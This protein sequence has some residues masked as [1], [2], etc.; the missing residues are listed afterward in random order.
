M[1]K[2][3]RTERKKH[4]NAGAAVRIVIWL[5]V[6]CLLGGLFAVCLMGYYGGGENDGW[7]PLIRNLGFANSYWYDDS[8]YSVGDHAFTERITALDIDWL[9]GCVTIIPGEGDT[10]TLQEQ[11]SVGVTDTRDQLRWRVADGKLTVKFCGPSRLLAFDIPAKSLTVTVPAAW[12]EDMTSVKLDTASASVE[13]NGLGADR[14]D[15]DTASGTVTLTDV[16]VREL[17]VNTVSGRIQVTNATADTADMDTTSG[18]I[19][20]SGKANVVDV[21][22]VSGQ[23]NL[24]LTE[25]AG[26]VSVSST[27]GDISVTG[28]ADEVDLD[29]TSGTMT[30]TLTQA[31]R[32]VSADSVSGRL[33]IHL[34]ATVPGF[35]VDLDSVSGEITVN[36]FATEG[37]NRHRVY[38]DGSMTIDCDTVSGNVTISNDAESTN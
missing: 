25:K 32:K 24:T 5:L 9:E 2:T 19:T 18:N 38:G 37:G 22:T 4:A 21:D 12:L 27:S 1:D 15:V 28:A 23:V 35:T 3:D 6:L 17:D 16:T 26:E 33:E 30:L 10:L 13:I 11:S 14:L 8:D 36:G 29:T 7:F 20:F 34:P 31:A